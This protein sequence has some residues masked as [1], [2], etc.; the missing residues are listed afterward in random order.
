[1]LR[2]TAKRKNN[3]MRWGYFTEQQTCMGR[4]FRARKSADLRQC[5]NNEISCGLI[6]HMARDGKT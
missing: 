6:D 5:P 3:L 2:S 1:M 4:K